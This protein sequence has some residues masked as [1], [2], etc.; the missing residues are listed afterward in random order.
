MKRRA[1]WVL[2]LALVAALIMPASAHPGRTD[3]NGGHW[4]RST[5]EY[6]YHHG[7]PE[8]QHYNGECPYDFDDKTGQSS[9]SSSGG[10]GGGSYVKPKPTP[11]PTPKPTPKPTPTPTPEPSFWQKNRTSISAAFGIG[12]AITSLWLVYITISIYKDVKKRKL[13]EE[14]RAKREA[15]R[16][17]EEQREA[18]LQ[19]RIRI[20]KAQEEARRFEEE[21]T[22]V[23]ELYGGEKALEAAGVP[24]HITF[25]SEGR[26]IVKGQQGW[27][28][29]FT[30]YIT[31]GGKSFHITKGCSGAHI[32][33]HVF[34]VSGRVPCQRC[35]KG[36]K[37]PS[38][39][40][41]YLAYQRIK[42]IKRKY[43]VD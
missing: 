43:K 5:G 12:A 29:A 26:P 20:A 40:K 30:V 4:N 22:K 32:E 16:L 37:L 9:G 15:A 17:L 6:H 14:L 21:R 19:E 35:A 7:Y 28:P 13:Q 25:D 34:D 11:T 33:A 38:K 18:E 27:G 10:G 42:G 41:W 31:S 23:I 36:Y 3:S 8:H 24:D 1:I 2:V 39:P